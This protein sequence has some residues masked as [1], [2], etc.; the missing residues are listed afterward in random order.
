M[1]SAHELE[2]QRIG[3]RDLFLVKAAKQVAV[4]RAYGVA[5]EQAIRVLE[6]NFCRVFGFALNQQGAQQGF[7]NLNN[8]INN[9]VYFNHTTGVQ[10]DVPTIYNGM[11]GD[12]WFGFED[13][14][15]A[16]TQAINLQGI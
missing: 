1:V 5:S 14:G 2:L 7:D 4:E 6:A 12:G 8:L 10:G 11:L 16:I 3:N 15:Y 9:P 13:I